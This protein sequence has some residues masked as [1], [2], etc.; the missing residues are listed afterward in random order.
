MKKGRKEG[1]K[2]RMENRIV[3]IVK[4]KFIHRRI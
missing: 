2:R 1:R 3:G 4:T